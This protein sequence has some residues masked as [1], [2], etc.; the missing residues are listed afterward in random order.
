MKRNLIFFIRVINDGLSYSSNL[1]HYVP[2]FLI[3]IY[4][5]AKFLFLYILKTRKYV[6][7]KNNILKLLF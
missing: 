7:H 5:R 4:I 2:H 1:E 3:V 6:K